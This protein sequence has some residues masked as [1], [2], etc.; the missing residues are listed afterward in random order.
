[1]SLLPMIMKH[2]ACSELYSK[3]SIEQ[4]QMNNFLTMFQSNNKS[5]T[6]TVITP[7]EM[8]FN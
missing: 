8:I 2:I 5:S 1:M 6:N 3:I 4:L 7:L